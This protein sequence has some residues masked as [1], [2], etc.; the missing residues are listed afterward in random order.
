MFGFVRTTRLDT[1]SVNKIKFAGQ[2]CWKIKTNRF[3]NAD[4]CAGCPPPTDPKRVY[5]PT[6]WVR[7]LQCCFACVALWWCAWLSLNV[8][9]LHSTKPQC[10]IPRNHRSVG[11]AVWISSIQS[12]LFPTAWFLLRPEVSWQVRALRL[13]A[14]DVPMRGPERFEGCCCSLFFW[15]FIWC[16]LCL[17][18]LRV[19]RSPA[20]RMR[21]WTGRVA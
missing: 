20:A 19:S 6:H 8:Q 13:G 7:D 2:N 14:S 18:M 3:Q 21:A 17:V 5:A 4:P 1:V 16:H 10:R 12:C 11:V 15:W 9:D